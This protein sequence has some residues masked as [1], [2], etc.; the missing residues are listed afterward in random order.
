[1]P[2]FFSHSRHTHRSATTRSDGQVIDEGR[3]H[4]GRKCEITSPFKKRKKQANEGEEEEKRNEHDQTEFDGMLDAERCNGTCSTP[5][6]SHAWRKVNTSILVHHA[7]AD[8]AQIPAIIF[9]YFLRSNTSKVYDLPRES[10]ISRL[11]WST[12][13]SSFT[14]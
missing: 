2:S 3:P 5:S 7:I 1:M 8:T 10:Y 6:T 9:P 13:L 14:R 4:G 12:P 11:L